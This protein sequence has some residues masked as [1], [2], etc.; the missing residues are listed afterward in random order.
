ML[1]QCCE[2]KTKKQKVRGEKLVEVTLG[3]FKAGHYPGLK[4]PPLGL[5]EIFE[6]NHPELA[7]QARR[8]FE[9]LR[10][11]QE[12]ETLFSIEFDDQEKKKSSM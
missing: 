5:N 2:R 1:N 4:P 9:N 6:M 8:V 11:G 12:S 3:D 7:T 10:P